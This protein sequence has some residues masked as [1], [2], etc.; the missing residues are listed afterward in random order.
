MPLFNSA[1]YLRGAIQSVLSQSWTGWEIIAVD[2]GSDDNTLDLLKEFEKSCSKIKIFQH[3]GGKNKGVSASRN[4]AI[5][6]SIGNWI[7]LLDADD[8]WYPEKLEREARIINSFPD[9]V[10]IYSKAE[11]IEEESDI[12]IN[13]IH[14][15]GSG[16][17]GEI[18]NAFRTLLPGFFTS[19]SAVTF[20]KETFL[21]CGGFNENLRFAEDTLLFH[22]IMEHGSVYC[23]DKIL[24]AHRIH[25]LSVV[26]NTSYEKKITARFIVYEALLKKV[27]KENMP[28]VSYALVNT[29]LKKIFRNYLLYPFNKPG[30][31]FTYLVRTIKNPDVLIRHKIRAIAFFISEIVFSPL[32]AA[33]LKL[34]HI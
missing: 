16:K 25:N 18:K 11:R 32:K 14:I 29:G 34:R 4:L 1:V 13:D 26:S 2:D 23:I 3:E 5:S 27:K 33:W 28:L 22:Q 20:K 6:K 31:A 7:A 15:Y 9:A 30:L 17:E 19:T 12:N 24:G 10:L 8:F 21:R